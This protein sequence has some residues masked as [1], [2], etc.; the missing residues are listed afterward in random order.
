MDPVSLL[1]LASAALAF[2]QVHWA[3]IAF[4]SYALISAFVAATKRAD[5]DAAWKRFCQR[6]SFLAPWNV[7][8]VFSLPGRAPKGE[9]DAMGP[10]L[11]V[12][13]IGGLAL[14]SGCAHATKV[15]RISIESGAHGL[16]AADVVAAGEIERIANRCIDESES[17]SEWVDCTEPA[18][19]VRDSLLAFKRVLLS[20]EAALDAS[21]S[22]GFARIAPCV[23]RSLAELTA[24]FEA[25][26][27]DLPEDLK[28]LA[29][30]V[31]GI[32]GQCREPE[33][34]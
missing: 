17:M 34:E 5:D 4:W 19:R 14:A 20:A 25:V 13:L 32:G 24:A 33:A 31:G 18:R 26:G 15:G 30:I 2:V 9:E 1:P 27:I 29:G 11:A 23:A 8:G 21:G 3:A 16:V 10:M 12:L 22:D 6:L 28:K 7:A